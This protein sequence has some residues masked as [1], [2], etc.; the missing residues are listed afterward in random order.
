M[1]NWPLELNG[2]PTSWK[3]R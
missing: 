1:K 3:S 2:V